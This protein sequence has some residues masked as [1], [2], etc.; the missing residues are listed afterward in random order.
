MPDSL[1]LEKWQKIVDITSKILDVPGAWIMQAN[2]KGVEAI[3]A[4]KA[5][6][7]KA[8]AG[9]CFHKDI[10]IY[11]KTVIRTNKYLYIKNAL[12][13]GGWDDNPEYTE[14]GLISYLGVP[15][16]WPNGNVF[17]TL[18]VMDINES[19]YPNDNIDLLLQL[20]EIID[21]DLKNLTLIEELKNKSE[22]DELTSINNRRGFIDKSK[23]LIGL[24]KRKKMKLV[25][26]YF[27]L[28][29]LKKVNDL[30]GHEAGDILIKFLSDALQ[31]TARKEDI[32]GRLGG[33]EFCFLGEYKEV[34]QEKHILKSVQNQFERFAENDKRFQRVSYSTGYK[35]FNDVETFSIDRMLS[36]TDALMYEKKKMMKQTNS[37]KSAE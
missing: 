19:N 20:K 13:E 11:C 35:V 16:E 28:N 3:L 23:R 27:D 14:Y 21:G 36:E 6:Q 8:P 10:N 26:M 5:V 4:S 29:D 31:I 12:K 34:E 37:Q 24:A 7:N 15:L 33:D 22:T 30:Y 9:M 18:C 25:V 32:I 2:I 17:G 1:S